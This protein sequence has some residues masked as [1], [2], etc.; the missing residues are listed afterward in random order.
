MALLETPSGP[1]SRPSFSPDD[2]AFAR[3]SRVR[4]E[5]S[6]QDKER[7]HDP[8]LDVLL[9]LDADLFFDGNA[10]PGE[11]SRHGDRRRFSWQCRRKAI[12]R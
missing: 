1:L 8:R 7:R 6:G 12:F 3:P 5:I 9:A 10:F 11:W 2:L 4:S